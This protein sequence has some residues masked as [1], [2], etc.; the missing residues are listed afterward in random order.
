METIA[1]WNNNHPLS[2]LAERLGDAFIPPMGPTDFIESELLRAALKLHHDYY[3]NGFGN[4]MSR[5][6]A[7]IEKYHCPKA[8]PDFLDSFATIKEEV[9]ALSG[10][11][12]LDDHFNRILSHICLRL[13][14]VAK[15]DM[16]TLIDED[17]SDMPYTEMWYEK[18][19]DDDD[20]D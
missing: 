4:N 16:L 6:I 12:S 19:Y 18:N 11:A 20:E 5:Q 15:G 14:V 2:P 1:F 13:A 7:Y 3:N 17:I 8:S 9:M 10:G